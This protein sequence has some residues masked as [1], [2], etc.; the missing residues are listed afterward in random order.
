MVRS[1]SAIAGMLL[2][3]FSGMTFF[4][5][6]SLADYAVRRWPD[7][8]SEAASSGSSERRYVMILQVVGAAC[9]V[10]GLLLIA[11]GFLRL[12]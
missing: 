5:A 6:P 2:V 1:A 3:A 8:E 12:P 4:Y 11:V 10:V 9:F 7:G